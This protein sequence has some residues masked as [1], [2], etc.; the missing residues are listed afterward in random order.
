MKWFV[1][2]AAGFVMLTA[3]VERKEKILGAPIQGAVLQIVRIKETAPDESI[4]VRGAMVEKC[5]V[6]G[7]WFLLRDDTGIIKVD[8]KNAG[9]VVVNVPL[10][11]KLVVGGRVRT[12]G[13]ERLIDATGIRY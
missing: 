9:F 4:V 1:G 11:T 5:P 13:T 8:T 7:C 6:A 2:M 3:C 10:Q 12:N